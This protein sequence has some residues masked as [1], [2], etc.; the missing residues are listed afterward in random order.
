[1]AASINPS[2]LEEYRRRNAELLLFR[3]CAAAIAKG[4][5]NDGN[6]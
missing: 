3:G 4:E 6:R 1:M 2:D 5:A